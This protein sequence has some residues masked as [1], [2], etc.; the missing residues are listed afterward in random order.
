[1]IVIWKIHPNGGNEAHV[2]FKV[3]KYS[4]S[5]L[6]DTG[7]NIEEREEQVIINLNTIQEPN[8]G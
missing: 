5:S 2:M 4:K 8:G 6:F 1:M 7:E 3:A